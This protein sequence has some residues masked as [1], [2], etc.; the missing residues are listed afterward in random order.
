MLK[1]YLNNIQRTI[2]KGDATGSAGRY[3]S[4]YLF[5]LYLY[6]EKITKKSYYQS[7]MVFQ[8][9]TKYD[10][11]DKK[12]N[13]DKALYEKLNKTYKKRLIP[14][15]IFYYIYGITSVRLKLI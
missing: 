1:E 14:E 2:N 10:S 8:P 9:E 12:P 11:K 7:M 13:I 6:K 3:G 4:G 15:E 5:P